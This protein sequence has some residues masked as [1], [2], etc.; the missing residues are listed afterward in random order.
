MKLC[1][2]VGIVPDDVNFVLSI[3]RKNTVVVVSPCHTELPAISPIDAG[4]GRY[5]QPVILRA[6]LDGLMDDRGFE[7]A[8]IAPS[9]TVVPEKPKDGLGCPNQSDRSDGFFEFLGGAEGDLLAGLDFDRLAGG[10]IPAHAGGA[11]AH[12]QNT[13]AD[14]ADAIPFL[15]VLRH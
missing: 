8:R 11:L 1:N 2:R 15:E 3:V 5:L 6:S 4:E 14:Q 10:R 12:L 9:T 7:K 13:Q